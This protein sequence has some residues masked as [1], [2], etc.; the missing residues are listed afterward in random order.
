MSTFTNPSV[1]LIILWFAGNRRVGGICRVRGGTAEE[2]GQGLELP[3]SSYSSSSLSS[4]SQS[5][6]SVQH[7]H[8]YRHKN[9]YQHVRNT[10]QQK[11]QP[12]IKRHQLWRRYSHYHSIYIHYRYYHSLFAI[13]LQCSI[14]TITA[15]SASAQS[16]Q[17]ISAIITALKRHHHTAL[18]PHHSTI[19]AVITVP[20]APITAPLAPITADHV[21]KQIPKKN[22]FRSYFSIRLWECER[23]TETNYC[24]LCTGIL[25]FYVLEYYNFLCPG[26]LPFMLWNIALYVLE[27]YHNVL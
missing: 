26:I 11:H 23:E 9:H 1:F 13:L 4:S 8:Q 14:T 17:T 22:G 16:Q 21:A 3:A 12:E 24:H 20:W 19:S 25:P 6:T 18:A 27:Y 7:Q 5:V 2:N 15:L 10:M